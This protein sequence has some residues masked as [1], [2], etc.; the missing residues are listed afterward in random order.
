LA[1]RSVFRI[2]IG[3]VG[4]IKNKGLKSLNAFVVLAFTGKDILS[5][6][7]LKVAVTTVVIALVES[8]LVFV[9]GSCALFFYVF[10]RLTVLFLT[11]VALTLRSGV[12]SIR[13]IPTVVMTSSIVLRVLVITVT[14]AT[15]S[16][17]VVI[18]T[19]CEVCLIRGGRIYFLLSYNR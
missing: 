16:V 6:S 12:T 10:P 11:D 4:Y 3:A 1:I 9:S 19:V 15:V 8:P 14:I 13:A 17:V 7:I 5:K 2:F 18:F